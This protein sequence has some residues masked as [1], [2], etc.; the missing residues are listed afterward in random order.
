MKTP[1][2][3]T[4]RLGKSRL[5]I[6][7]FALAAFYMITIGA[8]LYI[9]KHLSTIYEAAVDQNQKWARLATQIDVIAN[10]ISD[11]AG[12]ANFTFEHS[13]SPEHHSPS[14][15]HIASEPAPFSAEHVKTE[16]YISLF[17][18]ELQR[19]SVLIR[20][21][22]KGGDTN[23]TMA[24]E[25]L[26]LTKLQSI[27]QSAE[28]QIQASKAFFM[29]V[30]HDNHEELMISWALINRHSTNTVRL[31]REA[32]QYVSDIQSGLFDKQI[33]AAK[34]AQQRQILLFTIALVLMLSGTV[35]GLVIAKAVKA[36]EH[37]RD[38]HLTQLEQNETLLEKQVHELEQ[39]KRELEAKG[40]ELNELAK[41][42][43]I[44]RDQAE[45]A[46]EAKSAFLATMSHEIRTPMN[47]ILGMAGLLA[48]SPL[49][50]EQQQQLAIIRQS[51]D[52]LL[53][54]IDDILDFSKIEAGKL[55]LEIVDF[56][57]SQTISSVL[58]L[59]SAKA[60]EKGLELASYIAS[61]IPTILSGDPSRLRQI[62]LNLIGN[63]IKFTET[64]GVG[65]EVELDSVV[66]TSATLRFSVTDTGIGI[67]PDDQ[68][69]LFERFSQAD[70]S[71]TRRFGG[72][73]LGLA[74]SKE[75]CRLMNGTIEVS[76]SGS[77]GC[78][79]NFTAIMEV[80][81]GDRDEHLS[82][83]AESLRGRSVLVVDD[84]KINRRI[85]ARLL[86]DIGMEA[87]CLPDA[88]SAIDQLTAFSK[89][90]HALDLIIIDHRMPDMDG[91]EL[92]AAIHEGSL[93]CGAKLVLSSSATVL[94]NR[95]KALRHG[96]DQ[97]L[98]KPIL[99]DVVLVRLAWLFGVEQAD[100]SDA[101]QGT[102]LLH[103]RRPLN[104]K[105][106]LVVDDNQ[107]NQLLAVTILRKYGYHTD[108]A[109]N[110]LEAIHA[111]RRCPYDAVLMDMQM[112]ELDGLSAT[113]RIREG[114]GRSATFPIIAM[115][116]NVMK[117][118]VESCLQAGMNDHIAKPIDQDLLIKKLDFW[119]GVDGEPEDRPSHEEPE[120]LE[121][122]ADRESLASRD[123]QDP[124]AFD[125][126]DQALKD[127][128]SSGGK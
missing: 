66:G 50:S 52:M 17:K 11:M 24:P 46:N 44:T 47:G 71:T 121:E 124:R 31:L 128:A 68:K 6:A 39:A 85:F 82:A 114:L 55:D 8:S 70:H 3:N 42:L 74:I 87:E 81:S 29:A 96:F 37:E 63:G 40:Q 23:K 107:I 76:S 97:T 108:V 73:G 93:E 10:R 77:G 41:N 109:G 111:V 126:L 1:S 83:C 79:F 34:S 51:G 20:E 65:L 28:E 69:K 125:D 88:K 18:Q 48:D 118:D 5:H 127:F 53:T 27:H 33:A 110:G 99:K 102:R 106:V 43:V 80:I 25:E 112:P 19:F 15:H 45:A 58:E 38:A 30:E 57:L 120:Q 21:N 101:K 75:L 62:L 86:T 89:Q 14:G 49:E 13:A 7:Y 22:L 84:N 105:R 116:A 94:N 59:L 2:A 35:Y 56:D 115:T 32:G 16:I 60:S 113:R 72:T 61:D 103:R 90:G 92:A 54:I 123:N 104:H 36:S 4:Q 64:G 26:L 100:A 95:V 91:M 119:C 122:P 98:P 67:M 78:C 117:G 12:P 9:N